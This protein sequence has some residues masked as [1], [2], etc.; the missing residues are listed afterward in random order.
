VIA[1]G[2]RELE[3]YSENYRLVGKASDSLK[4]LKL[5]IGSGDRKRIRIQGMN[6]WHL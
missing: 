6:F 2:L 5:G 4:I 3:A 1:S